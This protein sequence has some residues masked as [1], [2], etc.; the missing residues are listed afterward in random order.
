MMDNTINAIGLMSGTSVDGI[1]ASILSSDGEE[2]ISIIGNKYLKYPDSFRDKLSGYI[3]KISSKEDIVKT[4]AEYQAFERE[5]TILHSKICGNIIK[6]F[7][8][9]I[10]LI[11][12]H[13]QTIIHRPKQGYSVQMGDPNLLSYLTKHRVIFDY[14]KND[15]SNKGEGAPLT[16][17]YHYMLFKKLKLNKPTVFMN[18]GGITNI[19]FCEKNEFFAKDIGP[20]NVLI[21]EYV[22]KTKNIF[23]D[24]NGEIASSGTVDKNL[25]NQFI[26]HELYN[27]Y[28]N[29]SLDRNDYDFNFVRGLTFENSVATLT[30]FTANIL[31]N[32]ISENFKDKINI[33]LCGGG[34]L[35][36]TLVKFLKELS[37]KNISLID[38]YG[39]NGDFIESQAFAF[40]GIRSLLKKNLTFPSTTRVKKAIT[41]GEIYKNF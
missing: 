22:K 1:D 6:E 26:E 2:N 5:L 16:P 21:D 28:H 19:T 34:R 30:Y 39:L 17:I 10:D 8:T 3:K 25:I 11:G 7:N 33:I 38:D 15:I 13:G 20:G 37:K 18:L 41:G 12:F 31:S 14:R 23:Y 27:R 36:L 9:T 32:Y 29:H 24:K 4:N 35:N 40:L